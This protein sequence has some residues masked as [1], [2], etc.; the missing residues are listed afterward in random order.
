MDGSISDNGH[1]ADSS[2]VAEITNPVSP[3]NL[4]PTLSPPQRRASHRHGDGGI[5]LNHGMASGRLSS[6]KTFAALP[7]PCFLPYAAARQCQMCVG[8]FLDPIAPRP[9]GSFFFLN[10][11]APPE[12]SP[13]PH[14]AAFPI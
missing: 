11:P 1:N 4:D 2:P 3:I 14:P 10:D 5:P 6:H 7:A 12:F 9:S 8:A 13:L